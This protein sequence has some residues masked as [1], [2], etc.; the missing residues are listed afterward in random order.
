VLSDADKA[1]YARQILLSELGLAGQ[2]RLGAAEVRI[3]AGTDSRVTAVARDYLTRAGVASGVQRTAALDLPAVSRLDVERT[4][5]AGALE[6]CAAWLLGSFTAVEA[7]K[8][9]AGV[10]TPAAFDP[11]FVLAREVG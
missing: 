7:I 4:A 11:D 10:G 3:A 5:G 6:D 9:A 8:A 1:L 2:A